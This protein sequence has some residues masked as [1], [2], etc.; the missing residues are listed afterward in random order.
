VGDTIKD[1]QANV[2]QEL[3]Q[4]IP[5]DRQIKKGLIRYRT[6]SGGKP[7]KFLAHFD[8]LI[9]EDLKL[10][11]NDW[12]CFDGR[13]FREIREN[14]KAAIDREIVAPGE[15]VNPFKMGEGPFLL[16]IGQKKSEILD[17]FHVTLIPPDKKDPSGTDHL[18]LVPKPGSKFVKK[19]EKVEFWVDRKLNL[20]IKIFSRDKHSN[21]MTCVFKDVKVD[22]GI[23]DRELWVEVPAG[24]SY[25]REPLEG[26]RPDEK[27]VGGEE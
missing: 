19:Y 1:L 25:T 13:W 24:Y 17:N 16:P 18:L 23:P 7:A 26:T 21:L 11:Q 20:P 22:S 3:Y 4:I 5:D 9:H 15:K 8:V 12:L 10:K 14:N 6:A 27:T 2:E